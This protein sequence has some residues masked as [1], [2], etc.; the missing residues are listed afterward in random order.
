V[1]LLLCR[2][3]ESIRITSL[4]VPPHARTGET[5][6]LTCSFEIE[7]DRL[8]SVKWYKDYT[9]FFRYEPSDVPPMQ[10]FE[11][12]GVNVDPDRSGVHQVVL[13]RVSPQ[14][15]GNYKCE[16]STEAPSFRTAA[17]RR[18]LLVEG[19]GAATLRTTKTAVVGGTVQLECAAPG[20]SDD[21]GHFVVPTVSWIR[22]TGGDHLLTVGKLT[23]THDERFRALHRPRSDIWTLELKY[24][25][26]KDAGEYE[27]QVTRDAGP[28]R[29]HVV[30]LAVVEPKAYINAA[31]EITVREGSN[32]S[33]VCGIEN[34]SYEP[35]Y[36]FW[37]HND[38]MIS[39]DPRFPRYHVEVKRAP[40]AQSTL[41]IVGVNST[42]IGTIVCSP[43][44]AKPAQTHL[45]VVTPEVAPPHRLP[46]YQLWETST[47]STTLPR[48]L[49]LPLG[50]ALLLR[51]LGV[52]E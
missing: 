10:T 38:R 11:L 34:A 51:T 24:V 40:D 15:S 31:A 32:V 16:I 21:S 4:T 23:Y 18:E 52:A 20:H 46:V 27:C 37:Y 30:T 49:W 35:E 6:T 41:T 50:G 8:Y 29:A 25:Q 36:V 42:D 26:K 44:N 22:R 33:L 9:E 48:L 2:H 5:V 47:A 45:H 19:P 14:T 7:G 13:E 17:V 28:K 39:Y 3:T 43:S 12:P 1:L